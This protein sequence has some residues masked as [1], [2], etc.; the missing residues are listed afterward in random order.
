MV[1][2]LAVAQAEITVAILVEIQALVVLAILARCI[3]HGTALRLTQLREIM[4]SFLREIISQ[5]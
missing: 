1:L 5:G 4:M 2:V 3:A